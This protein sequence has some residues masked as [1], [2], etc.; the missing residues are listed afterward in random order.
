MPK[1]V[2][3]VV[4]EHAYHVG[5]IDTLTALPDML[6]AVAHDLDKR[7]G[8]DTWEASPMWRTVDTREAQQ[9]LQARGLCGLPTGERTELGPYLCIQPAGHG[10]AK[11]PETAT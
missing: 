8:L 6:R 1:R 4:E 5:E 9:A 2:I 10:H 3:I 7:A 11:L